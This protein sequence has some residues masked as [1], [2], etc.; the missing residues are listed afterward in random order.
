MLGR[1]AKQPVV[2]AGCRNMQTELQRQLAKRCAAFR[3]SSAIAISV[4]ASEK[5]AAR[6]P[7]GGVL[8]ASATKPP[9][10]P[11][12][13]QDN[14]GL[15]LPIT[16]TGTELHELLHTSPLL[17]FNIDSNTKRDKA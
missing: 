5:N 2:A 4:L 15:E 1:A 9:V 14:R 16:G 12:T 10:A 7:S 11:A 3:R 8:A 17:V 13:N 6:R